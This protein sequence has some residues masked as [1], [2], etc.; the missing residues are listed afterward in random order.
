[1]KKIVLISCAS[2][3]AK[4]KAKAKDLYTSPLF[5]YNL[6]YAF[7]LKPDKIF[8]LS[9]EYGLLDL[10]KEIE[11]YNKTLNNMSSEEIKKWADNIVSQIREIS[12]LENDEFIFLAGEKYRKFIIPYLKSYK[13]PFKGL[14]IGKQLKEL[15]RRT[16][17]E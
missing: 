6:K 3:K 15:K 13:I 1:M 2:R 14:G 7:S 4:Q 9:A 10:D 17:N 16:S 11:P 8:I 5:K 12:D